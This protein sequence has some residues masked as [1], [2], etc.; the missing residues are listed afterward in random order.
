MNEG[1]PLTVHDWNEMVNKWV[2]LYCASMNEQSE[3]FPNECLTRE[4]RAFK[5][6]NE[7]A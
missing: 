7:D 6:F 3:A 4:G 5:D 2:T 1:A